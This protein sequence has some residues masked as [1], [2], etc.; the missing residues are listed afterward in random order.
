MQESRNHIQAITIL[1]LSLFGIGHLTAQSYNITGKVVNAQDE[2]ISQAK[3]SLINNGIYVV[4]GVDGEFNLN[5]VPVEEYLSDRNKSTFDGRRISLKCRKESVHIRIVDLT[6]RLVASIQHEDLS[7]EYMLYPGAYLED[8]NQSILVVQVRVG[9]DLK[10]FKFFP[11]DHSGNARGLIEVSSVA[12]SSIQ[13]E[14]KSMSAWDTLEITHNDYRTKKIPIE[15]TE[16]SFAFIT[17]DGKLPSAPGELS[18]ESSSSSTVNLTWQ[19]NSTDETGFKLERSQHQVMEWSEFTEIADLPA[20]TTSYMDEELTQGTSYK[21]R[22]YAYNDAGNSP[23]SNEAV[24]TTE[25][26]NPVTL[27]APATST[28]SFDITVTYSWPGMLGSTSDRFVLEEATSPT[29]PFTEIANSPYNQRPTSYTFSLN[30]STGTYYYR[31]RAYNTSGFTDYSN[32]ISV[33]VNT[34]VQKAK[35]KI[36]NNTHYYMVDIR[37]NNQQQVGTGYVIL[38]GDSYTF[39]YES[40]GR[41]DYN[42]GVGFW[43]GDYRDVWFT[44]TGSVVITQGTTTTVT[45]NN[46][47]IAQMLTGFSSSRD[48]TGDYWVNLTVGYATFRFFSNGSWNF[49]DNGTLQ[50]SGSVSEVEWPDYSTYFKFR[51]CPGCDVITIWYPFGQFYYKN[52]PPGWE[53]I[54]YTAQ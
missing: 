37:L 6:G 39:E 15:C 17:L 23:Y 13:T 10:S 44:L 35:L 54:Q 41:V 27:S 28:G 47:T 18:A 50:G 19:D 38:A 4:T 29:G 8:C 45:F 12:H 1:C 33:S 21:Y 43:D 3:V 46:P 31:S 7:G 2:P 16:C 9:N 51:V 14:L 36:V 42:L 49:Y 40:G 26:A 25:V 22:V 30:K 53:T 5:N 24:A 52:G 20:N 34:P 11:A 32:V 48:W